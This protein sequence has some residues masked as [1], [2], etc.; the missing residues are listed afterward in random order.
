[1]RVLLLLGLLMPAAPLFAGEWVIPWVSNRDGQW[2]ARIY[3]NNESGAS[4]SLTLR[5]VRSDGSS[6]TVENV[7]LAP[8]A[9]MNVA[10]GSFFDELGS[11]SGYAVWVTSDTE[12]LTVA[13]KVSALSTASRDSPSL[14]RGIPLPEASGNLTFS[15]VPFS[16]TGASA[17]VLVNT[18]ESPVTAAF[19]AY[20][21]QGSGGEAVTRDL[22]PG[23]PFATLSSL[24]FPD[25]QE[26]A[27]IT[28]TADADLVGASFNF[29]GLGEPSLVNAEPR[30]LLETE[31]LASAVQTLETSAVM[32]ESVSLTVAGVMID[33][34]SKMNCPTVTV[35]INRTDPQ[36]YVSASLDWGD[37]CESALGI[38]HAGLISLAL[39]RSG[40]IGDGAWMSGAL[41]F[42]NFS[43]R[44]ETTTYSLN[45]GAHVESASSSRNFSLAADW[46]RTVSEAG[47]GT[48]H[49]DSIATLFVNTKDGGHVVHGNL[50]TTVEDN[51][52]YAFTINVSSSDPLVFD[53][54]QC[55]YPI[56]GIVNMTFENGV[57][58][59]AVLDF[60][61]GDCNTAVLTIAGQAETINLAEL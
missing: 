15:A 29:N 6:Q 45:G 48:A 22:E 34:S 10:A 60:D 14:G 8:G 61:T 5:A 23:R 46:Q 19:R 24:L 30:Y 49:A 54:T 39:S 41:T 28:V 58:V 4:A 53:F 38:W 47:G 59:R 20:N 43:G 52:D 40:S 16:E 50:Q 36:S 3:V 7:V 13:V 1:M 9:A 32:A 33:N 42:D 17:V 57:R 37:G 18:S 12:A 2:S 25:L 27:Y 26:D 35:E 55:G 11:G 31:Q 21:S 44:Y 51:Q 56:R